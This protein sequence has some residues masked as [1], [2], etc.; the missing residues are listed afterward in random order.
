MA[1]IEWFVKFLGACCSMSLQA[2]ERG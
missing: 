2:I 1:Y